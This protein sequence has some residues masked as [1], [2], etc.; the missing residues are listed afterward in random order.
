MRR[1]LCARRAAPRPIQVNMGRA[2][3]ASKGGA[4][5]SEGAKV[6][7]QRSARNHLQINLRLHEHKKKGSNFCAGEYSLQR[8]HLTSTARERK[9]WYTSHQTKNIFPT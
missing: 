3:S 4:T 1:E 5:K 8:Y 7:V 9:M 6:L 2:R